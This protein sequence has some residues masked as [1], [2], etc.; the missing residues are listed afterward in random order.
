MAISNTQ[1][2]PVNNNIITENTQKARL[3]SA[4]EEAPTRR[5]SS[6]SS[7]IDSK[8]CID[9][10]TKDKLAKPKSSGPTARSTYIDVD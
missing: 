7:R 3:M 2:S 1:T 4:S 5:N 6:S 10:R 8:T 9:D